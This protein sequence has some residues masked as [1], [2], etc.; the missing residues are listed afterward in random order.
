M[1]FKASQTVLCSLPHQKEP[2]VPKTLLHYWSTVLPSVPDAKIIAASNGW[3]CTEG[4]IS[5]SFLPY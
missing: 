3:V 5:L 2:K 1:L 4:K